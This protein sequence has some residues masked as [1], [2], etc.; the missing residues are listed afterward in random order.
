M[1]IGNRQ[2]GAG[3]S[4]YIIA[5]LS[6]NH[7]GSLEQALAIVRAAKAAGADAVKLQTYTADTMTLDVPSDIFRVQG[8]LWDGQHLYELYQKAAT[9]WE[10]HGPIQ[11]EAARLGLD[12]FSTPFDAT[13]VDFLESLNVPCYKVASF[14]LVDDPLLINIAK[15]HKPV[16]MSTGMA[17]V[18]EIEHALKVL[19]SNGSGE[20]ILL[21]CVSAYPASPKDMNLRTISDMQQ[22]FQ[23]PVGLSDHTLGH[24]IAAASVTLGVCV[25]EKHMKLSHD[26]V[27]VDAKFSLTPEVFGEMVQSIRMVEAALGQVSYTCAADEAKNLAYRRSIFVVKDIKKGGSYTLENIRVIRPSQGLSPRY[28]EHILG[29]C[30]VK[31]VERGTPLDL[32]MIEGVIMSKP[33]FLS[34]KIIDLCLLEPSDDFTRYFNW[35]NDQEITQYMAVG[36]FPL[37]VESLRSYVAS[38]NQGKSILLGIYPKGQQKHIGNILLHMIDAQN[39]SGEIG[40]LIGERDFWGKGVA[41]E[42]IALLSRHAFDRLNLHKLYAGMVEGNEASQR[43]FEKVGFTVEG[44][45]TQHFYLQGCYRDCTRMGLLQKDLK[46]V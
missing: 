27:S 3:H 34:G 7:G 18:E 8:S 40:I 44:K 15:T 12:F 13:A 9:P 38:H 35:V 17:T 10:W 16:I 20:I 46:N 41:T 29:T 26:E 5:E 23:C 37:S 25:I 24:M 39:R 21:K 14:E 45:L 1:Q 22:R 36:N 30:A 31:D 32:T 4:C 6:A 33:V 19:R 2:I 42:A 11:R 43:A 28:Y